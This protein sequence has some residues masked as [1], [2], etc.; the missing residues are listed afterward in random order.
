MYLRDV[1][2][3][4]YLLTL[5]RL[6]HFDSTEGN[7]LA[8]VTYACTFIFLSLAGVVYNDGMLPDFDLSPVLDSLK[9]AFNAGRVFA[10]AL[11]NL[12]LRIWDF[13]VEVFNMVKGL[14]NK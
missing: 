8:L 14:F 5:I 13:G 10:D 11:V 4:E 2:E 3:R 9:F 6:A 12:F 1:S 7:S